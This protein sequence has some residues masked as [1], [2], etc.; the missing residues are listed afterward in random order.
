M[1]LNI[2]FPLKALSVKDPV[3]KMKMEYISLINLPRLY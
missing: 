3:N 2:I 1:S